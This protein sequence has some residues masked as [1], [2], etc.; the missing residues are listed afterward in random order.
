MDELLRDME[1]IEIVAEDRGKVLVTNGSAHYVIE[2]DSLYV[3]GEKAHNYP[4][5]VAGKLETT[6]EKRRRDGQSHNKE[7]FRK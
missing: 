6:G 5:N 4:L 3:N 7:I 2:N 1:Q